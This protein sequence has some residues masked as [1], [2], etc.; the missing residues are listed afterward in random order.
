MAQMGLVGSSPALGEHVPT[1]RPL[2]RAHFVAIED[3]QTPTPD[4]EPGLHVHF[5]SI[6]HYEEVSRRVS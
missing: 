2:H 3:G 1:H 6:N 4:M 5:S